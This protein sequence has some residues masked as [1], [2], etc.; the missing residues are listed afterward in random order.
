[1]GGPCGCAGR[2][3]PRSTSCASTGAL[4]KYPLPVSACLQAAGSGNVLIVTCPTENVVLS[5]DPARGTV[6]AR[7]TVQRPGFCTV[8]GAQVWVDTVEGIQR[9]D[10]H[11]RPTA[12][13]PGLTVGLT[14]DLASDSSGVVWVRH[15]QGFLYRIDPTRNAVD[16]QVTSAYPFSGGSVI[17]AGDSIWMSAYD[18]D[19]LFHLRR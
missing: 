17:V 7:R 5:I 1:M 3:I 18:D 8:S 6:L 14:G 19:T 2:G 12:L 10:D 4:D 16:E 9:M 11:L 15:E 13:Y